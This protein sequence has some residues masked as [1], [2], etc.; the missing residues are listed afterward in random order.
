MKTI[1]QLFLILVCLAGTAYCFKAKE[2]RGIFQLGFYNANLSAGFSP[3]LQTN[4]VTYGLRIF[5]AKGN[6]QSAFTD[7]ATGTSYPDFGQYIHEYGILAG[8]SYSEQGVYC[9]IL[10]GL[11]YLD[12]VQCGNFIYHSSNSMAILG[13]DQYYYEKKD[14]KGISFPLQAE[15]GYNIFGL[16]INSTLN[17]RQCII[18]LNLLLFSKFTFDKN[19][20]QRG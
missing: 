7:P 9:A 19:N 4:T 13:S 14:Y 8:Y 3:E 10:G 12:F 15:L 17:T 16:Q 2:F 1:T 5:G 6:N 18:G 20:R 11:S